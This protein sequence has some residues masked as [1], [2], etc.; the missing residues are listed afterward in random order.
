MGNIS[1]ML[2]D[3]VAE[4]PLDVEVKILEV[5]CGDGTTGALTLQENKCSVY[6]GVELF[7]SAAEKPEEES[8]KL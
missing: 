5:G 7:S 3:Y 6:C 2:G 4:F 1:P 8:L